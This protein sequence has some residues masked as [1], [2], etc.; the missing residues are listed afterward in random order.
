[1]AACF[2]L[3]YLARRDKRPRLY[4]DCVGNSHEVG[5]MRF[6]EADKGGEQFRIARA[7]AKLIR[8]N[9]GQVE[10]PAR[11]ALVGKR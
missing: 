11:P 5:L 6:E 10:E 2:L 4:S 7:F 1:L 3:E 9:S 8:P